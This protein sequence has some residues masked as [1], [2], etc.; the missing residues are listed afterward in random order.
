MPTQVTAAGLGPRL[1]KSWRGDVYPKQG[2]ILK[3]DPTLSDNPA[4][5][6]IR[7]RLAAMAIFGRG[8][9]FQ[10]LA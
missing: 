2:K 8:C 9:F 10:S 6:L 7:L 1:A 5:T 4:I 3:A